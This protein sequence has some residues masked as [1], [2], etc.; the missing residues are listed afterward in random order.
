[1]KRRQKK[2]QQHEPIAPK[3]KSHWRVA[4]ELIM[5]AIAIAAILLI[6]YFGLLFLIISV[7]EILYPYLLSYYPYYGFIFPQVRRS[8]ALGF[9]FVYGVLSLVIIGWRVLRRYRIIQMGFILDELHYVSQGHYDYQLSDR[10]LNSMQ[11]IVESVNRL[12]NKT[13]RAMEEE[14]QIEQSKDE[15]IV[16][17]SHDIRTPL[18]SIIGYVG[19]IQTGQFRDRDEAI[20]YATIA[21]NKARHLQDMVEDLFEYT[22]VS[23]INFSLSFQKVNVVRLLEQLAVEFDIE[24]FEANRE[25]IIDA[26][27]DDIYTM[28]DSQKM[29]RVFSNLITNALKYGGEGKF[30]KLSV[31]QNEQTTRFCV[32][33]DG[34]QIPED[35]LT[36]LFQRFYRADQSRSTKGSGLGLAIAESI[37]ALHH[38]KIWA[39]SDAESTRFICE[40]PNE[41][42]KE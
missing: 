8:L 11:P 32:A 4:I 19:L 21:Y 10:H 5:E 2:Q 1:M 33:N 15:L 16:N 20:K 23:Q 36:R 7:F 38:G 37:V 29:V 25:L 12:V 17:M 41:Q 31:S 27:A 3:G 6:G 14:R 13:V 42:P 26:A 35:Q 18:T 28:I 34:N 22:K 39:E 9:T 24:V 40:I 30:I